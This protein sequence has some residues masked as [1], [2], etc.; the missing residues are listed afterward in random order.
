[1]VPT[2]IGVRSLDRQRRERP[3]EPRACDIGL[4][5]GNTSCAAY[6]H[7]TIHCIREDTFEFGA[8]DRVV[9]DCGPTP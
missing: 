9:G 7:S 1:M 6:P 8:G 3:S 5:P 2:A 4:L